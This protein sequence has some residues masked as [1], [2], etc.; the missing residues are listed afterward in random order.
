MPFDQDPHFNFQ[1]SRFKTMR[2]SH[3]VALK[4]FDP[5]SNF[6]MHKSIFRVLLLFVSVSME[7]GNME[8]GEDIDLPVTM[9]HF[10]NAMYCNLM[11]VYQKFFLEYTTSGTINQFAN[12]TYGE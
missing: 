3:L 1:K 6:Q 7:G 4:W 8:E 11:R 10:T 2:F 12:V 9:Q 5:E